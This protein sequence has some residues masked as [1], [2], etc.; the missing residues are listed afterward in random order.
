[1]QAYRAPLSDYRFILHELL[2]V[3][4]YADLPSFSEASP[5]VI[6]AI[7]EE[8][9]RFCEGVLHPLQRSADLEGCAY[10]DG[11]VVTPSGFKEA[12]ARFVEGGWPTLSADPQYGGQ[13]L[14]DYLNLAFGEM[15]TATNMAFY[16]YPGLIAPAVRAL[17]AGGSEDQKAVYLPKLV[18]GE[19]GA[20]M[21]LTEPHCGTDLGLLRTRAV[22]NGDGSFAVTGQKIWI[23]SGE[24]DL[25]ENIIHLVLARID[26]APAGSKGIS[27]FLVPKFLPD[28]AGEPGERNAVSCGGIESKMGL[29]GSATCFMNYDGAKGWLVGAPNEGLRIMFHM[30]NEARLGCGMQGLALAECAFQYAA[31]FARQRLQGRAI[32]G[33][34]NP[35]GPADPIIAHPDVR[36]ML[37]DQKVFVEGARAFLM[38][39]ALYGDLEQRSPDPKLREKAADYMALLTPVVKAYLTDKGYES[40][41]LALQIHGGAGFTNEWGVSQLLRDARITQIYEGANGV[42]ALDL[43]GR[44]LNLKGGRPLRSFLGE[45]DEFIAQHRGQP[46]AADFIDGLGRARAALDQASRRLVSAMAADP[47]EAGATSADYLN[48]MGLTCLA[49]MWA[50]MALICDAALRRGS[51][52]QRHREKIETARY[53]FA[54]W[55]PDADAC[56]ARIEAGAGPVMAVEF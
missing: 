53:F 29:H 34:V 8:G 14:P 21:N 12:Y 3:S 39:T 22:D 51:A 38:W 7:L 31:D 13:G 32:A 20:T 4:Q 11:A 27:L 25:T 18:S 44:K 36:R 48:L 26:G 9:A 16:M 56:L 5:D 10:A 47:N 6:D 50:R 37:M 28:A 42:Q 41:S 17:Q 30:M 54:R 35:Q 2:D 23:T 33:A 52:D 24:H 45:L 55:L 43:V 19:W 1:M 46:G 40:I 15:T 49:Y